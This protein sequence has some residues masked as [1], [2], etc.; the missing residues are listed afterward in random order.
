VGHPASYEDLLRLPDNVVGEIL[1]G[2]L[3]A[4]PRPRVRHALA[5]SSLTDELLSPFQKGRGGPGGWWILAEPEL[6]LG[7]DV[8]VPDLGGWLRER[9]PVLPDEAALTL[10]P[11]WVCEVISPA[12]SRIDRVKKLPIY[13]RENVSHAW[14]VDPALRTL[15]VFRREGA[16]WFLVSTASDG[17]RVRAQ[18][19]NAIEIDRLALWGEAR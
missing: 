14:I 2:E 10:A 15:E 4:S 7:H 1:D 3:H 8:L 18:P 16:G 5:A 17:D 6:H 9:L 11:D 13:A 19:F 12:A